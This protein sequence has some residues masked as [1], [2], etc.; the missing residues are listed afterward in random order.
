MSST[1]CD[2][3]L[4]KL[5]HQVDR[6][7][8][9]CSLI[10]ADKVDA[11]PDIPRG[12]PLSQLMTHL[13]ECLAGFTAVLRAARPEE[14]AHFIVLKEL[15]DTPCASVE[16]AAARIERFMTHIREGFAALSDQDLGRTI[17]TVFVPGGEAILS[18]LLVNLEHLA[19]HKYQLFVYLRLL[20]VIVESR[21]LYHFSGS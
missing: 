13:C 3:F 4:Q 16:D 9:L 6:S 1:L 5:E 14:L 17:P 2:L 12:I 7:V 15:L 18:L 11:I 10:P 21:D 8:R 20:G 19:S